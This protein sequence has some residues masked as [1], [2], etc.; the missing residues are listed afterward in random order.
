MSH[1]FP[2]LPEAILTREVSAICDRYRIEPE[3]AGKFL[4]HGFYSQPDLLSKI[5][6]RYP[7]GDIT[8]RRDYKAIIK[9]VRKKVYYHLRQYQSDSQKSG[10]LKKQLEQQVASSS[11]IHQSRQVIQDLLMSHIST[12]E[13][14]DDYPVFYKKLF[15]MIE[16]PRTILDVGCGIHPL[17]YPFGEV[18]TCPDIYAATDKSQDVI[19]ILKIFSPLAKPTRLMPVCESIADI[20][21]AD[22]LPNGMDSF[23]IAFMLKLIPV[24]CRQN[25]DILSHLINVPARRILITASAEAMTRRKNIRRRE[26]RVLRDFIELAGGNI[27]GKFTITNEFG[28]LIRMGAGGIC[29]SREHAA[30]S[31]RFY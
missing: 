16:P 27:I 28:Y 5:L 15:D 14:S 6:E 26:D 17:S 1:P 13:R 25:R 10:E 2:E 12:K 18:E 3:E 4:E 30:D 31:S 23:D 20:R 24:I 19:E 8:K 7:D 11:D 21:W 29:Q 9:S 22:Y